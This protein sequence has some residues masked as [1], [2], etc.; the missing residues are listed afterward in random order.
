[1]AQ[2]FICVPTNLLL[3]LCC[4]LLFRNEV[5]ERETVITNGWKSFLLFPFFNIPFYF[6]NLTTWGLKLLIQTT[7]FTLNSKFWYLLSEVELQLIGSIHSILWERQMKPSPI[8]LWTLY[9]VLS[10]QIL[11]KCEYR[12]NI[13]CLQKEMCGDI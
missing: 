3:V 11:T 2:T 1:M 9:I 10:W 4:F 13:F 12:G 8:F 7:F 5:I 6:N